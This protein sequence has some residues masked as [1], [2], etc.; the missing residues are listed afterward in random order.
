MS[1]KGARPGKSP[2]YKKWE[3]EFAEK[4]NVVKGSMP[5]NRA[6]IFIPSTPR[7]RKPIVEKP[8]EPEEEPDPM[9]K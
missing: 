5:K 8:S 1:K 9:K 4:F 6:I 3:K 7:R 2:Y